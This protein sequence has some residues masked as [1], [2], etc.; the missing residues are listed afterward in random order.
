MQ[1]ILRTY[2]A[3]GRRCS[4]VVL[5]PGLSHQGGKVY[6]GKE[7]KNTGGRYDVALLIEA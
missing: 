5:R 1:T 7:R 2:R 6:P 3:A 4:F